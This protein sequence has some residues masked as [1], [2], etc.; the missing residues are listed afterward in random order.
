MS[1]VGK[2]PIDIPPGITVALEDG[3][4]VGSGKSSSF[5][6]KIHDSVSTEISDGRVIFRP[7]GDDK[8]SRSMWGTCRSIV[9][10]YI[11]GLSRPFSKKLTFIGTGYKANLQGRNLVMQLGYSHEVVVPIPDELSVV[12][13]APTVVRVSGADLQQVGEFVRGLQ[14][15][16]EPEPYNGKGI[17]VDNQYVYRKEGKKK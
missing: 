6:F 1:R 2:H 11:A 10:K 5:R 13:E 8:V 14:K 4:L 16:R 17:I 7:N 15:Y 12:C 3:F 9:S